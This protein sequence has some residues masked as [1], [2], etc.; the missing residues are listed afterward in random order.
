M[1]S[2]KAVA[3]TL[4][5]VT[6]ASAVLD[7]PVLRNMKKTDANIRNQAAGKG[8]NN[9]ATNSGKATI[10]PKPEMRKYDPG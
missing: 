5:S 8:V 1:F 10:I 3:R 2:A 7:G 9:I 4:G 6:F